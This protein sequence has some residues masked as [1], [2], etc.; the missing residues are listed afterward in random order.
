MPFH[1]VQCAVCHVPCHAVCRV[2]SVPCRFAEFAEF[3]R[4][5]SP[6]S[7][8]SLATPPIPHHLLQVRPCRWLDCHP[9]PPTPSH[10]LC[11]SFARPPPFPTPRRRYDLAAGFFVLAGQPYDAVSGGPGWAGGWTAGSGV[12]GGRPEGFGAGPA[13]AEGPAVKQGP[14]GCCCC[15]SR[16][17]HAYTPNGA[18]APLPQRRLCAP[19]PPSHL[20][21]PPP[22]SL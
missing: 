17:R 8:C 16:H 20:S 18:A 11:T 21:S 2:C 1:A 3:P 5:W 6:A 7:C 19:P 13:A 4:T 10:L 15:L 22:P 14:R 9:P 12:W